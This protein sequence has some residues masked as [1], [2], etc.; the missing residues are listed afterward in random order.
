MVFINCKLKLVLDSL[1]R[2][3]WEPPDEII[4]VK[5]SETKAKQLQKSDSKSGK[6]NIVSNKLLVV[7]RN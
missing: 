6:A 4:I 1:Y 5:P 7:K 2:N 3:W